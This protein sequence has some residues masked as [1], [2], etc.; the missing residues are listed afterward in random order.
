MQHSHVS[1]LSL[2]IQLEKKG[3]HQKKSGGAGGPVFHGAESG[4]GG[5]RQSWGQWGEHVHGVSERG[6]D[7]KT[8]KG[9]D[10]ISSRTFP[11]FSMKCDIIQKK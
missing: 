2:T 11:Q 8:S 6:E 5:D 3:I 10:T 7:G 4:P 1:R 9:N